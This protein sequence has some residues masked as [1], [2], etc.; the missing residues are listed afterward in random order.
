MMLNEIPEAELVE[1]TPESTPTLQSVEDQIKDLESNGVTVLGTAVDETTGQEVVL[2][3]PNSTNLSNIGQGQS[4]QTDTLPI[5]PRIRALMNYEKIPRY[6]MT[7]EQKK[8]LAD[9]RANQQHRAEVTTS[10]IASATP[11]TVSAEAPAES[12]KSAETNTA[13]KKTRKRKSTKKK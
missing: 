11:F 9:W 2:V 10:R 6:A 13:T 1:S 3:D 12:A 8:T 4:E 5:P 7:A